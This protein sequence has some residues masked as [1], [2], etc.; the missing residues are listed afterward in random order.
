MAIQLPRVF[1]SRQLPDVGLRRLR[2]AT[3][4]YVWPDRLPPPR[5][6]L[7]D[8]V[9]GCSGIVS[10]LSDSID[11]EVFEAAG[12]GLRVVSNFAVGVNNIDLAEAARRGIAI[13]NTPDVLTDATADIAVALLLAAARHVQPAAD[14]VRQGGWKTWEPTGWLGCDLVGKTLGIVGM[15]R[16]GAAVAKRMA[17][18]WGMQVLYTSRTQKDRIGLAAARRVSLEE[19]LQS[20]DFVSLHTDLSAETRGLINRQRLSLMKPTSV[21]VNTSRGG[22][23]DQEALAEALIAGRPMAAGLDVTD[24]EPLSPGHPLVGLANCIILPHIGSA[25]IASRDAMANICVDNLLAGLSG[26]PLRC[27]VV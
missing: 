11:A 5:K 12:P 26:N 23:I 20:S 19:L 8:S 24:P 1:V 13:G 22:V 10:L 17:G 2:Q 7:L 4:C 15:G 27:P 14:S 6:D 9:Q 21:L 18:G 16:I 3:D 25:T